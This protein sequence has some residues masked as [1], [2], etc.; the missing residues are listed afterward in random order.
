[1]MSLCLDNV[2]GPHSRLQGLRRQPRSVRVCMSSSVPS[3]HT[4]TLTFRE[5]LYSPEAGFELGLN[6]LQNDNRA[7]TPTVCPFQPPTYP[8]NLPQHT[9]LIPYFSLSPAPPC[10]SH[11]HTPLTS[12]PLQITLPSLKSMSSRPPQ[13][14]HSHPIFLL[15]H[16]SISPPQ[17]LWMA[18]FNPRWESVVRPRPL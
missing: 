11:Y 5:P 8:L 15:P 6:A 4:A 2:P 12:F 14:L 18:G 3:L 7:S 13:I 16:P 10:P 9:P 1:L 17:V